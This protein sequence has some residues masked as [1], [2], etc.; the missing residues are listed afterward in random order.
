MGGHTCCSQYLCEYSSTFTRLRR[1]LP[2]A[3]SSSL[4]TTWS[5]GSTAGCTCPGSTSTSTNPI[6]SGLVRVHSTHPPVFATN[7]LPPR[8]PNTVR[9]ACLPS[10]RRLLPVASLPH[11]YPHLPHAPRDVSR[12]FRRCQ[13]LDHFRTC[14]CIPVTAAFLICVP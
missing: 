13:H 2:L 5:T 7:S 6:T 4:P 3:A 11:V 8:S 14:P 10:R 1:S 12:T 9:F